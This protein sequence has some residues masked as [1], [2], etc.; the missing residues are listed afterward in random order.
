[1]RSLEWTRSPWALC[2]AASRPLGCG[3]AGG[4]DI[5]DLGMCR[6]CTQTPIG[7]AP[8]RAP[9]QPQGRQRDF[10]RRGGSGIPGTRQ[11]VCKVRTCRVSEGPA[12][13][14]LG[15]YPGLGLRPVSCPWGLSRALLKTLELQGR[16][17]DP[18]KEVSPGSLQT[19]VPRWAERLC[20]CPHA[21]RPL[22]PMSQPD[23]WQ[24]GACL[25]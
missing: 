1:M 9:C 12:S 16:E 10:W 8:S 20:W 14:L 22:G 19:L 21:A 25:W 6:V 23:A 3:V 17:L 11:E 4:L 7:A 24:L 18:E 13:V 5:C 2:P 15:A